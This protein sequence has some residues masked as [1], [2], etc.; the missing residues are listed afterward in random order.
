M[1]V[2]TK[3]SDGE[4]WRGP[5]LHISRPERLLSQSTPG[6][7]DREVAACPFGDDPPALT[8]CYRYLRTARPA[9]THVSGLFCL[10]RLRTP[11]SEC[12][13]TSLAC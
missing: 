13:L 1:D 7:E 10:R 5:N 6:D 3:C 12:D 4:K 9:V 2:S 11:H 8:D